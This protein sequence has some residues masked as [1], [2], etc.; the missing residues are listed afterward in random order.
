MKKY[1]V[2][3][4]FDEH[5]WSHE[6]DSFEEAIGIIFDQITGIK[7][8]TDKIQLQMLASEGNWYLQVGEIS[9]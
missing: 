1:I 3:K 7:K 8:P 2:N 6:T 5:L 4:F 9:L